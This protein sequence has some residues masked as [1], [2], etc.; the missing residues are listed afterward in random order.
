MFV[1]EDYHLPEG[2]PGRKFK[3]RAVHQGNNVKDQDGNWAI[4]QEP[5]SCPPTMAASKIADFSSLLVG[6]SGEQADAE[7]A[8]TH[9]PFDGP[10]MWVELPK[11]Q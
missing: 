4:F 10:E 7:M 11:K 1:E 8:Y 3:G 6:H 5:Q 2:K 9:A